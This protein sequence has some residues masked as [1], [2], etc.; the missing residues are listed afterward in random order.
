LTCKKITP[1][2]EVKNNFNRF[3][4][5]LAIDQ[6]RIEAMRDGLLPCCLTYKN[7]SPSQCSQME[8]GKAVM[9]FLADLL[10]SAVY[11][12]SRVYRF[13]RVSIQGPMLR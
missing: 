3:V 10:A 7:W 4:A 9:K 8:V 2:G 1:R 6:R 11:K 13:I 12:V 5:W